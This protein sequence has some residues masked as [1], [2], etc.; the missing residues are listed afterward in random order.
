MRLTPYGPSEV[1]WHAKLRTGCRF[2]FLD[3][4]HKGHCLQFCGES[5]SPALPQAASV[6]W[7]SKEPLNTNCNPVP[8]PTVPPTESPGF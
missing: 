1:L 2:L 8:V 7:A 3:T 4:T 6:S 5:R